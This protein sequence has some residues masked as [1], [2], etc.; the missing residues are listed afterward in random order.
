MIEDI[1]AISDNVRYVAIYRVMKSSV[2]CLEV[3]PKKELPIQR[4]WCGYM[5][6]EQRC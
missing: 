3:S 5:V 4:H 2:T 1:F 6:R